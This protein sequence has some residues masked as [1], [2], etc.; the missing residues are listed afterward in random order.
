M[1]WMWDTVC[2]GLEPQ[3]WHYNIARAQPCPNF[4]KIHPQLQGK[5][6]PICPSTAYQGA[7]TRC[8]QMI[9]MWDTV[10]G[11]LQPQPWHHNIIQAQPYPI[12]PK[13]HPHLHMYYGIRVH[14][15]AHPQLIK[16]LKHFAYI[17]YGCGIQ[18]MGVCSLNHDTTTSYRL[19]HTPFFLK[20]PPPAHVL[21]HKGVPICPSTA[22]QGA[23]TLCIQ[24]IWMWD[25]VNGGWQPP[26]M[27][28]PW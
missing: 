8:I 14:P 20:L 26:V 16:V 25:T 12:F 9:W 23:N 4:P 17:Q 2:G 5:G 27:V 6:R 19:S 3:P 13:I 15:Y 22:S 18:S 10:N 28:F 11:G 24:P 1:I 7:K 21:R